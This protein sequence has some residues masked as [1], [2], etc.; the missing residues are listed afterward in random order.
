MKK[1]FLVVA[2]TLSFCLVQLFAQSSISFVK[3][4]N[5]KPVIFLPGLGCKGSVWDNTVNKFS[6]SY[7]CYE[8]SYA[9]FAGLPVKG[10]FSIEK[11]TKDIMSLIRKEKLDHPVLI[12]HSLSGFIALKIASENPGVFSKLIIVDSFPFTLAAFNPAVTEEQAEQQGMMMKEMI[13]KQSNEEYNKS[14]QAILGSLITNKKDIDTVLNWMMLSDRKAIAEAT[15]EMISTDLRDSIK[16]IDCS[17]LIIGTWKGKEQL[18]VTEEIAKKLF[19]IQYENL[20]NKSIVISN[21][22]KHFVMLDAPGWLN[23]QITKFIVE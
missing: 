14:E 9:G 20:K 12:G 22:S 23:T 8:I 6:G 16:N 2:F 5:G 4:G 13:L 17:T 21:N 1:L 7:C 10:G 3:K 11:I 19:N 15:F 18:G